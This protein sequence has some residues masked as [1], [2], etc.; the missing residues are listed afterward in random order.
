MGSRYSERN[1]YVQAHLQESVT[2]TSKNS[3]NPTAWKENWPVGKSFQA[4]VVNTET[5]TQK[6]M[7][8]RQADHENE[9]SQSD[10]KTETDICSVVDT[11][12]WIGEDDRASDSIA[13]AVMTEPEFQSHRA[14]MQQPPRSNLPVVPC[15]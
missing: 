9:E 2:S 6:A 15:D 13:S 1:L 14:M 8:E 10:E 11:D 5:P 4:A 7:F 12:E 3:A